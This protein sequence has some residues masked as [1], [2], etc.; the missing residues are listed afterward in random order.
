MKLYIVKTA[1][2]ELFYSYDSAVFYAKNV[3]HYNKIS[4]LEIE[5][6]ELTNKITIDNKKD[7]ELE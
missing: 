2:P 5:E 6:Y 3:L 1:K 4:K 7:N